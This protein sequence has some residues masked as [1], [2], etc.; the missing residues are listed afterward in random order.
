MI[1]KQMKS[2]EELLALG[3]VANSTGIYM[4]DDFIHMKEFDTIIEVEQQLRQGYRYV[5]ASKLAYKED[6]LKDVE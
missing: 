4:G 6:W 5:D 3:G 1:K 2:E